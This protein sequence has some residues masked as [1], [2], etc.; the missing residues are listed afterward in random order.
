MRDLCVGGQKVNW[1]E[2]ER[3]R[4]RES[5]IIGPIKPNRWLSQRESDICKMLIMLNWSGKNEVSAFY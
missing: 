1:S 3:E 4:E 2:R 5:D